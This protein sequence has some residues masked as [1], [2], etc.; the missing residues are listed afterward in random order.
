M[1]VLV[2]P[3]DLGIGGSQINAIELAGAVHRLGHETIVFGRPGPLVEKVRELGLE[4]VAAPEMGRRPS[5]AVTR[6]LAGLVESRCIDILHGY[7]W[8]PSL[9]CYLA[10]RRLT[11]VAAVSTVMSMAVAPFIP[12]HVPLTVGTHQI[13]EA[14]AGIGRSAVTVLEPPVD[15]DANRPGLDLAQGELRRRWGI[16][17][18]GHVVAVVSRLARELKLEGILSAMEAV[19]SLPAGMRVCL[20]IAGDGPECAEVTER[21]AQINLRTG[22][23]TVVLAGELAD[24]RAAYDVADVCLGMGGSALR[25]LAFGKPL[26]VQGEEGFW[27]LLTPSS[28]ETF[29]WQGWYGVGSGQAGGAST[30]RQILFEILP[31]EGLRAELGDFGRRVVVHRYSLG[32]AAEAQLATYAA[33]LDAVSSGRRATFRELEAAGHFLRYKS[34]R[35]QARLT[36]RGSADDF[37]ASPVAAA[38]PVQAFSAGVSGP[39]ARMAGTSPW[40]SRP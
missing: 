7:E 21:A 17:D 35:L 20:L 16:A 12:K 36:G 6:A 32:H 33:A 30:L 23:Q 5:V 37:N 19:A 10:A 29:L 4:F 39:V 28:L 27:E 26:V 14:E 25:A 24:P 3:H 2:Y 22:R 9:E 13:A 38:Q 40:R 11:R 15:V 34:R 8:P 18:A 1:R 31:A